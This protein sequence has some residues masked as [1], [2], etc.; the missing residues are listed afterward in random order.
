MNYIS[1]NKN[2]KCI[3]NHH[4]QKYKLDELFKIVLFILKTGISYR[5]ITELN[6]VIHW[7][8]IYKFVKK[9]EKYKI[10]EEIYRIQST[11]YVENM[12]NPTKYLKTDTSF[13]L[14]K[15]GIP[16]LMILHI[17]LKLKNIKL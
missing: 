15:Y 16:L 10:I 1:S 4:R 13:I 12:K 5:N 6:T 9:L 17:I 7:N 11:L 2:L 3:F 14:N 8:T